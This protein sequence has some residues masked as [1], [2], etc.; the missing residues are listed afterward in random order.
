MSLEHVFK[1]VLDALWEL[2]GIGAAADL[3]MEHFCDDWDAG[4]PVLAC[5][6]NAPLECEPCRSGCPRV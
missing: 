5:A 1:R 3:S 4:C 6:E 2:G